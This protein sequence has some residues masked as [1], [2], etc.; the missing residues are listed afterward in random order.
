MKNKNI[1]YDIV[2]TIK[3]KDD[4]MD[5][6]V[7]E[8]FEIERRFWEKRDINWGIVTE[9]DIDKCPKY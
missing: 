5:E 4:L 8:K 9:E 3:P 7:I 6:R 1:S 2:R